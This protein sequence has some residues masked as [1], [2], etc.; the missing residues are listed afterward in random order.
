MF[1]FFQ[2][3]KPSEPEDLIFMNLCLFLYEIISADHQI[4][5]DEILLS[6]RKIK[7]FFKYDEHKTIAELKKLKE[8]NHFN[9]DLSNCAS[10]LKN[11]LSYKSRLNI[12]EICW[13]ILLVDNYEDIL[14]TATVRKL[15]TLL[16]IED[17][18]FIG[19]RNKIKESL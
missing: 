13:N 15:G 3:K 1:S 17:N 9:A 5:D 18:D 10:V 7:V 12:I 4:D 16:G 11:N 19:I 14:E 2:K 8:E 6:A